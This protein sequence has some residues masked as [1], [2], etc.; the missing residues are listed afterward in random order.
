MKLKKRNKFY[1]LKYGWCYLL[2][3]KY[4]TYFVY[5]PNVSM[6]YIVSDYLDS[7]GAMI[8]QNFF[9]TYKEAYQ[10]FKTKG[11]K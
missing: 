6:P 4:K 2:K 5:A 3:K 11:K 7:I 9:N 8:G 1:N 10:Y